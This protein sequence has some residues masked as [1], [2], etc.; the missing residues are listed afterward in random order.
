M[1]NSTRKIQSSPSLVTRNLWTRAM[2]SAETE[3][4]KQS[5]KD[6]HWF[7]FIF[8]LKLLQFTSALGVGAFLLHGGHKIGFS[9]LLIGR[10]CP[11]GGLTPVPLPVVRAVLVTA[12]ASVLTVATVAVS[13]PHLPVAVRVGAV[14]LDLPLCQQPC[15]L[16]SART[17]LVLLV[18]AIE[19]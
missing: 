9:L 17:S 10:L 19:L 13:M 12:M 16:S 4:Q 7:V 1:P 8:F 18:L 3:H 14:F 5:D 2:Q 11:H 15:G 6:S